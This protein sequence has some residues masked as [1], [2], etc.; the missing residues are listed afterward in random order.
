MNADKIKY[1]STRALQ[2][3]SLRTGHS[4]SKPTGCIVLLT[5]RCNARCLHCHSWKAERDEHEI[6]TSEWL[7]VLTQLRAWLGPVF[8]SITGG[9]TLLKKDAIQIARF[10]AYQGF[11]TEFLTNGYL[12]DK[13]SASQLVDSGVKR[14]KV[15][16]DGSNPAI[17]DLIRGQ[18][19]FFTRAVDALKMLVEE[20]QRQQSQFVLW[21]KTSI[22]SHNI[23]DLENIAE[24]ARELGLDGVEYQ[25]L[26]PIYYSEQ[27]RDKKWFLDNP[28][29]VSDTAQAETA[30]NQLIELKTQGYPIVNTVENLEMIRHYFHDPEALAH[31]VHSHE[32]KKKKSTCRSWVGGLQI[33]PDGGMKMCHFME[34]FAYAHKG[35]IKKS[36]IKRE[37]CWTKNCGFID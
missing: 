15:S 24:I 16:I 30:I 6:S 10:A 27:L 18:N 35:S 32:Y 29:W 7:E 37:K 14:I 26:E 36:W 8:L 34:P 19:G 1:Y 25:A 4:F 33:M 21:A 12:V 11:W 3:L 9:E 31:K 23:D 22:M 28:L 5:N 2:E 20:K 17:H 13:E